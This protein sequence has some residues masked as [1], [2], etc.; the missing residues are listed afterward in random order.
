MSLCQ[1]FQD[2]EGTILR[3][4]SRNNL[5]LTY[6]KDISRLLYWVINTANGIIEAG[7]CTEDDEPRQVNATGRST[8]A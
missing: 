1:A 6:Q 5:Y 7:K 4:A 8:V 3:M 2:I